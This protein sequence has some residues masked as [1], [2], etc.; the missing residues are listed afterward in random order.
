MQRSIMRLVV[1]LTV[2]AVVSGGVGAAPPVALAGAPL[3]QAACAE[4]NNEFQAACVLPTGWDVTGTIEKADD[5]DAYRFVVLDFDAVA[6]VDLFDLP[7]AYDAHIADWRG[8][9]IAS[10]SPSGGQSEMAQVALTMP[11]VYYVFVRSKAGAFNATQPYHLTATVDYG[12]ERPVET[13]GS[14]AWTPSGPNS[15]AKTAMWSTCSIGARS[16]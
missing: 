1:A 10:S 8:D 7:A 16:P 15:T 12:P 2:L 4:P 13:P 14:R 9:V 11:G 6:R 5:V 3:E